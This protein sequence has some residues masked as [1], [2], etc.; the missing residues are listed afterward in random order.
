MKKYIQ[1]SMETI[2]LQSESLMDILVTSTAVNP[3]AALGNGM[4]PF[5]GFSN[6][7]ESNPFGKTPLE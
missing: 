3:G 4:R 2:E 5:G 1:P 7:F 6:P